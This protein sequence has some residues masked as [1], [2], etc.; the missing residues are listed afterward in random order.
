MV[1]KC[2]LGAKL[3]ATQVGHFGQGSVLES[4]ASLARR[5][6]SE[7]QALEEACQRNNVKDKVRLAVE[8][9]LARL[10]LQRYTAALE[11][12]FV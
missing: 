2:Q 3:W 1:E 12:S 8:R 7:A 4:V 9:E 5:R 11:A 6:I 10:E